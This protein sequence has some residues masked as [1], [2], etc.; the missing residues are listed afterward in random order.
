MSIGYIYIL[1]NPSMPGFLKI[2][3]TT[4]DVENR[5]KEL[6]VS[7]GVPVPFEIEYWCVTEDVEIVEK[8][9]HEYLSKYRANEK[10]EFFNMD[11]D[12]AVDVISETIKP[13]KESYRRESVI[14]KKCNKCGANKDDIFCSVCGF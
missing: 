9:V 8:N 6:S 7:T 14:A 12:A 10:R 13:L 5:A 1:S 11:C 2:G 4:K 3:F